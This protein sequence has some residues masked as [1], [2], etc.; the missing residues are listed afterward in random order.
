M[1]IKEIA[2]IAGV[3]RSTVDKVLHGRKGVSDS[4][5]TKVQAIIDEFGYEPNPIGQALKRQENKIII[6]AIITEIDA[7]ELIKSGIERALAGYQGLNA[8]IIYHITPFNP[9]A[10]QIEAIEKCIENKVDGIII[11]PIN[12][13]YVKKALKKAAE[14]GI[15][16]ITTNLDIEDSG[17][18]CFVGQDEYRAGRVAARLMGEFL[19]GTG[20]IVVIARRTEHGG[21]KYTDRREKGFLDFIKE[22]YPYI[23]V[24]AEIESLE[25]PA[26]IYTETINTLKSSPEI[27]GI[28]ITCG[29]VGSVGNA[30]KTLGREG[31]VKVICFERYEEIVRLVNENIVACTIDS[32]L[33]MQGYRPGRLMIDHLLYKKPIEQEF[34]Y[35]GINILVKENI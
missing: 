5:R 27:T 3:H 33:E 14:A 13:P 22:T 16:V 34:F 26:T 28:Y 32:E 24:A 18:L 6:A 31:G 30:L 4:V 17:R 7:L 25:N 10:K 20:N 12:E 35:T 2:K 29:G 23:R 21:G 15:P 11:V 19:N 9:S 1:T 8:E